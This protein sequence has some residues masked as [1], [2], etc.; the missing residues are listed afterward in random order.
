MSAISLVNP[1]AP[2]PVAAPGLDAAHGAVLAVQPVAKSQGGDGPGTS[3]DQSGSGAGNGTNGGGSDRLAARH[4]EDRSAVTP[5]KASSKSVVDAQARAA[6]VEE[7]RQKVAENR[8]RSRATA[9]END[10]QKAEEKRERA[11]AVRA[12]ELRAQLEAAEDAKETARMN[13]ERAEQRRAQ[14]PAPNPIPTAPILQTE[15]G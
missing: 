9:A 3:T 11:S 6:H 4:A 2:Q 14:F 7:M 8:E 12:E 1:Y 13:A 5:Q 15:P 10:L